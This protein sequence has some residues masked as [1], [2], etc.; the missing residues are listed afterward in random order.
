MI[1]KIFSHLINSL[2][3]KKFRKHGKNIRIGGNPKINAGKIFRN[4]FP[5]V[6]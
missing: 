5:A 1:K 3:I 2:R 4:F 6:K